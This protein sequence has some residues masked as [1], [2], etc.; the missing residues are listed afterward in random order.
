MI[1]TQAPQMIHLRS[2]RSAK[3]AAKSGAIG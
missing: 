2:S 1:A 3:L